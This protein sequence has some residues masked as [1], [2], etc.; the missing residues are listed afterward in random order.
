MTKRY[1]V[2]GGA[3]FI[4]SH[5]VD[6]LLA[7]GHRVRILDNFSTGSRSNLMHLSDDVEIIEG[8][9]RSYERTHN[10]ASGCDYVVH[11]A[12]LPS[13]PRSVQDPLTSNAANVEGTLNVLLSARDVGV[14]RV[15][16]ASSSSVYGANP[17]LPKVESMLPMPVSP[18]GVS[19]LA[20][21]QYAYSFGSV[22]S[23]ETVAL[24]FF[25]VFGPRQN[26][27]SQYS[28][29]IPNF[30]LRMLEGGSPVIY[31]DGQQSRDFTYVSNVV[32]A[33]VLSATK[34]EAAGRIM[35]VACGARHT[36]LELVDVVSAYLGVDV[37]PVFEAPRPGDVLHSHADI[38]LA[39]SILD[40]VPSVGFRRGIE[41]TVDAYRKTLG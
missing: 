4:G 14:E 12:A 38:A 11:L 29:V 36:L 15:V 26:P 8:D 7:Q 5:L 22:Y 32:D 6:E 20:T 41:I 27:Y 33:I 21:E 13:V 23:M 34:P 10:A 2:T 24:R 31:G 18:Y 28:A 25:N 17:T 16:V 35:N 30:V 40:Y 3:G 37:S 39:A 19:K 1:L 9:I